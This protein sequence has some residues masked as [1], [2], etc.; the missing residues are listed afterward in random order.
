MATKGTKKRRKGRGI[1]HVWQ[2]VKYKADVGIYAKCSCGFRYLACKPKY[3]DL[4]CLI[5]IIA[6]EKLYNY[7]PLCGSRKTRY[8]EEIKHIDKFYW[9]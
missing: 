1:D 6:P 3:N 9:E 7:C 8:I 4:S 2:F 5:F